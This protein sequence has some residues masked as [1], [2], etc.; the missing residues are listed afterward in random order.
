MTKFLV[1]KKK[2][3]LMLYKYIKDVGTVDHK[4]KVRILS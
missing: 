4:I 2:V 1:K 3:M